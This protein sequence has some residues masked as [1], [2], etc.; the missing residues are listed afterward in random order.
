MKIDLSGLGIDYGAILPELI[1]VGTAI[2]VLFLDLLLPVARRRWLPAVTVV[3]LL[4]ALIASLPLWGQNRAAFADTVVADSL[5]AFFNVLLIVIT[6]LT[7]L[8][9]PRCLRA[10]RGVQISSWLPLCTRPPR[11]SRCSIGRFTSR[12]AS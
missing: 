2:V 8:I 4:A 1:V 11:R 7:V 3:G 6:I 12:A 5:A 10:T 9:S